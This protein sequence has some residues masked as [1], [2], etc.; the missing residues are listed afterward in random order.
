LGCVGAA[1]IHS[2]LA[3]RHFIIHHAVT[4][5]IRHWRNTDAR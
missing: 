3:L 5:L 1:A 4:G 2:S